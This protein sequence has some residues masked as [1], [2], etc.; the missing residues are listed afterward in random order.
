MT[1]GELTFFLETWPKTT[2][3]ETPESK[4][5]ILFRRAIFRKWF[6]LKSKT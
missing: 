6:Y 4:V 3:K 2:K 1:L 5:S